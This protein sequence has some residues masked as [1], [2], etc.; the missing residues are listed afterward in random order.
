MLVL[1]NDQVELIAENEALYI[2]CFKTME[3]RSFTKWVEEAPRIQ[4]T[5]VL[6]LRDALMKISL[7]PVLIGC[8][9]P[10]VEIEIAN[11][12][13]SATIKL[14]LDTQDYLSRKK[15]IQSEIVRRLQEEG[16]EFGLKADVIMQDMPVKEKIIVAEGKHPTAGEDAQ[17]RYYELSEKKPKLQTDGAVDHFDMQL[18]DLV[19]KGDWLGEKTPA[20]EGIDGITVKNN[21]LPAKTGRD[22]S[23]KYDRE[24][25]EEKIE[26]DGRAV[27][28]AKRSGAVTFIDQRIIVGNHYTL[29]GDVCYSTGNID[30][31]GYVTIKGTVDDCFSVKAT[32]DISILSENGVG[33][34]ELI[35]SAQGNVYIR[36]GVNGK[37]TA[38]IKAEKDVYAKY[39]NECTIEAKGLI[40]IGQYSYHSY[41]DAN[42]IKIESTK[43]KIVGG[44]AKAKYQ[45]ISSTIGNQSEKPT[46]VQVLGFNRAELKQELDKL[47]AYYKEVIQKANKLKRQVEIFGLNL[48]S[49]D[50]KAV[51][52]YHMM[53]AEFDRTVIEMGDIQNT[54]TAVTD[55]LRTRGDGEISILT[56]IHPKSSI[57][58][59]NLGKAISEKIYGSFYVKDNVLHHTKD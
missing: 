29:D 16:I 21:I 17:V 25:I 5:N 40:V 28:F 2:K 23:L 7:E 15:E 34:V 10:E 43:G 20:S 51:N 30:F 55:L 14:N 26:E 11:D 58:I 39:A 44:H 27:L 3:I 33:A 8:L 49:L 35:E 50:E 19:D 13:M 45:I 47:Q 9:K 57:K 24:T 56:E 48:N 4:I 52:T 37:G 18:F 36:G 6:A 54:I 59:K 42:K 31:D 32:K 53:Q 22:F 1:K 12:E 41:L 38:K 46:E